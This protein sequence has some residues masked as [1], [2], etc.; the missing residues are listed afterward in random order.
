MRTSVKWLGAAIP[1]A[2]CLSGLVVRTYAQEITATTEPAL[3]APPVSQ[4]E[5]RW[6]FNAPLYMW[7]AG[8]SGN[9][10][11]KNRSANFDLSFTDI[12][13]H[14]DVGFMGYFELAK[15]QYGFYVMPIYDALTADGGVGN[16]SAELKTQLW[17]VEAGGFYRIWK[18]A[19]DRP[20]SL[21]AVAGGR[22]WNLHNNLTITDPVLGDQSVSTTTWLCDPIVGLRFREY[23]T[24][25][26]HVWV[27]TDVGGFGI[28]EHTSR[29]TWQVMPLLA[30]DFTMPVIKKPST[31]FAGW[32]W[33]NIQNVN[34]SNGEKNAIHLD[35]S[36]VVVGLN[37]QLF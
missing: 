35:M 20:A 16:L 25:K 6:A 14:L 1:A 30:Y 11:V 18:S 12:Y 10:T 21:Y 24:S 29:F 22:Y 13:D 19:A 31:V 27:Q 4:D 5:D 3:A 34:S 26:V 37:V 7:A 23:L 15:P 36:G 33:L 9:V 2:V 32:R 8:M 28:S 17:I